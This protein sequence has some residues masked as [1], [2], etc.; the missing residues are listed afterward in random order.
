MYIPVTW[1]FLCS[2]I[3]IYPLPSLSITKIQLQYWSPAMF[4]YEVQSFRL[5]FTSCTYI[6]KL[7][8]INS[9]KP[10]TLSGN[11]SK[12]RDPEFFDGYTAP[13]TILYCI[14]R[15]ILCL[16]VYSIFCTNVQ[17]YFP[18][19]AYVL[20]Y[21]AYIYIAALQRSLCFF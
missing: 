5:Y 16:P 10:I 13:F 9:Y 17:M 7:L 2:Y 3:S 14:F 20:Y 19:P 12:Y 6:L 4:G 11:I 8:Y 1:L 18:K 21:R 15:A